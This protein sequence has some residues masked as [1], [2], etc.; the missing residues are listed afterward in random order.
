VKAAAGAVTDRQTRGKNTVSGYRF[1]LGQFTKEF[2]RR[3]I[4]SIASEVLQ[5]TPYRSFLA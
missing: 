5:D 2:G 1:V 3:R 4:D